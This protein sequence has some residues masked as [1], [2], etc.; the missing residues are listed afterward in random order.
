METKEDMELYHKMLNG[1][2][3]IMETFVETL[4]INENFIKFLEKRIKQTKELLES[5]KNYMKRNNCFDLVN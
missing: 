3:I 5:M 2:C 4:R 1:E